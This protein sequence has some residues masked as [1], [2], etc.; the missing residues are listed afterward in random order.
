MFYRAKNKLCLKQK[1]G[2]VP[3]TKLILV[4]VDIT[5]GRLTRQE[6]RKVKTPG[7]D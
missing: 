6:T 2:F 1:K 4:D 5:T 3:I 7:K